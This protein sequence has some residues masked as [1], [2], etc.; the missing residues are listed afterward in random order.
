MWKKAGNYK[1]I[2]EFVLNNL[3]VSS[4]KEINDIFIKSRNNEFKIKDLDNAAKLI[5]QDK[6]KHIVIC[7]DYDA[8]G[9]MATSILVLALKNIGFA[10][11]HCL[12]PERHTEGYGLNDRMIAEI[13]NYGTNV[14]LI[15]VDN[16]IVAFEQLEKAKKNKWDVIVTDHHLG[17]R[18][19]NGHPVLPKADYI[20]DPSFIS[21]TSEYGNYCGA[22]IAYKLAIELYALYYRDSERARKEARPLMTLAMVATF[23]DVVPLY[24]ENYVFARDGLNYLNKKLAPDGLLALVQ[25]NAIDIAE[26]EDVLFTIAPQINAPGRLYPDGAYKAIDLIKSDKFAANKHARELIAINKERKELVQQALIDAFE[27]ITDDDVIIQYLPDINPGIVGILAGQ[28][29]EKTNRPTIVFT[30]S[31]IESHSITG[32]AR[33]IPEV[34][35]KALLDN[36]SEY[37][38][39]YGGHA[40]AAGI[41]IKRENLDVFRNTI[42]TEITKLNIDF[43]KETKNFYDFE[44]DNKDIKIALSELKKFAPYGE[45]NPKPIFKVCKFETIPYYGEYVKYLAR[46]GVKLSSYHSSALAFGLADEF[47]KTNKPALL[48]FYGALSVN[49]YKG[50]ATPQIN[51]KGYEIIKEA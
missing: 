17:L 12:I 28:I 42:L 43:N 45:G 44:L 20:I 39:Y 35:I 27:N 49:K 26:D 1:T 11:V 31:W 9:V 38:E 50:I 32:S 46:E 14:C 41:T 36:V 47:R 33:S 30:D 51:F 13:E 8:D 2:A 29:C 23:A 7:G 18:D 24:G 15:T 6:N 40:G 25:E 5:Y 21:D 37:I 16:G 48:N 3:R 19:D 22:G 34:N 10:N 4:T